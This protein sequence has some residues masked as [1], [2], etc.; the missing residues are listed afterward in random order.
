[1]NNNN[2]T[3]VNKEI[4]QI[5]ESYQKRKNK[6]RV[7]LSILFKNDVLTTKKNDLLILLILLTMKTEFTKGNWHFRT[8]MS[9]NFCEIIADYKTN[10]VI[11]VIPKD[12]FVDKDEADANGR[13]IAVAPDLLNACDAVLTLWHSKSSNRYKKEPAYLEQIRNAIKKATL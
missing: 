6:K 7:K 1:M 2:N 3:D 5:Y 12:C 10:K 13:L 9:D 8:G 4:K 11:A